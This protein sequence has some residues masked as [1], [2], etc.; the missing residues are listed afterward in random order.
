MFS[1][2]PLL[3][4][5]RPVRGADSR[6]GPIVVRLG[7]MLSP[8]RNGS[9]TGRSMWGRA[10]LTTAYSGFSAPSWGRRPME[11]CRPPL[12]GQCLIT[13][14][15]TGVACAARSFCRLLASAHY[16]RAP[17]RPSLRRW[18][19]HS[20]AVAADVGAGGTSSCQGHA[21][22]RPPGGAPLQ[23]RL[24]GPPLAALPNRLRFCGTF[25]QTRCVAA[26]AS[27]VD[28]AARMEG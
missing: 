18:R 5:R 26:R 12:S 28:P 16:R 23:W 7:T 8:Q 9:L 4:S 19:L 1:R 10:Q 21:R 17:P 20:Y 6:R 3:V 25:Q 11:S 14:A 22:R 27:A 13:T 24:S 15:T 2:D